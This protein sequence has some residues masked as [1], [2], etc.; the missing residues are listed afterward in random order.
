PSL[1]DFIQIIQEN[2]T[3]LREG[4]DRIPGACIV[5]KNRDKRLFICDSGSS[6]GTYASFVRRSVFAN[7][8]GLRK[9]VFN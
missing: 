1:Q 6:S 3:A 4:R 7:V 8:A 2:L 5:Y 9:K